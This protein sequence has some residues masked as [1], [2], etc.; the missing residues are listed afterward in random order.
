M[1]LQELN[2]AC[3][4]L[5]AA[6]ACRNLVGRLSYYDSAFRINDM[7]ELWD[8]TGEALLQLPDHTYRG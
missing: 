4:R 3:E 2:S 7:L 5:E 8:T 6:Q 1:T